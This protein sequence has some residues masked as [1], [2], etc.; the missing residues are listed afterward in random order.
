MH[1]SFG[2]QEGFDNF[3]K[4]IQEVKGILPPNLIIDNLFNNV[5]VNYDDGF[6][7]YVIE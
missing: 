3:I 1:I 7:K 2:S 4:Y 5:D 6:I